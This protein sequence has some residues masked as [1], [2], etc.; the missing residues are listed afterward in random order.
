MYNMWNRILQAQDAI[1]VASR[2]DRT[3]QVL[4]SLCSICKV[5]VCVHATHTHTHTDRQMDRVQDER[6]KIKCCHSR[7]SVHS[8]RIDWSKRVSPGYCRQIESEK[9]K[10]SGR[11]CWQQNSQGSGQ[12]DWSRDWSKSWV[13]QARGL[14]SA[15][16]SS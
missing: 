3:I 10:E 9:G 15:R 14:P 6:V 11:L 13:V 2:R 1:H 8:G 5:C 12:R 7:K 16:E 4:V